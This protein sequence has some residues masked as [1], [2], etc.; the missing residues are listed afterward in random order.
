MKK[1]WMISMLLIAA[2]FVISC[3]DGGEEEGGESAACTEQGALRCSGDM[4]QKCDQETWKNFENCADAGKT[5]NAGKC[6][7]AGGNDNTDTGSDNTD[8]GNPLNCAEIYQCMVDCGAD[9]TC[10][11]NCFDKGSSDGQTQVYALIQCLN[12]CSESS[13]TDE[14]FQNCATEQCANEIDNCEGFG[15]GAPADENYHSPYGSLSLN[16]S[17]DQI[18]NASDGQTSQVGIATA[19]FATGTYGNGMTSVTPADAYLIQSMAS[20][21]VDAQYGNSIGIQQVP[22]Y[23]NN[24]QGAGGN[25]VVILD[26]PEENAAVGV[27]NTSLMQGAQAMLYVVDINWNAAQPSITCFHAFGEGNVN[28]TALGDYAN[29]GNIALTGDITLYSPKNYMNYGDISGQF[30]QPLT[31]CNPVQ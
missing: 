28:I 10:Q 13:T 19:A 3:G 21:S 22:V 7:A 25:P 20:Y 27:L 30:Q 12:T 2:L 8:T 23:N 5:C 4:V 29:H 14:E 31:I 26:I 16:F 17:I 24:G 1:F 9:Q 15:G 6:E 18:A 11:Q